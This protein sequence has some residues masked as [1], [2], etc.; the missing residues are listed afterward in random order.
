MSGDRFVRGAEVVAGPARPSATSAAAFRAAL[1]DTG[2][3]L[4]PIAATPRH[5]T[6][7]DDY[8]AQS[9]AKPSRARTASELERDPVKSM[10]HLQPLH[11]PELTV[12]PSPDS[13]PPPESWSWSA[14]CQ[15]IDTHF[16]AEHAPFLRLTLDEIRAK[17]V[18]RHRERT[19]WLNLVASGPSHSGK[20]LMA[21]VVAEVL[22]L[23]PDVVILLTDAETEGGLFGWSTRRA[24][25]GYRFEASPLLNLAWLCLDE[26]DKPTGEKQRAALKILQARTWVSRGGDKIRISP[27]ITVLMNRTPETVFKD[28][29]LRRSLCFNTGA[30]AQA[31]GLDRLQARLEDARRVILGV[32]AF[33][34]LNLD[35]L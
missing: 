18:L 13:A 11:P 20:S 24:G 21:E 23:D 35:D 22:G 29:F 4:T 30:V 12:L 15:T 2:R 31:I 8:E 16:P 25:A 14:F 28:E 27:A 6:G 33:E 34:R 7:H 3:W 5:E 32:A 17:H 1:S 26:F 19:G 10:N 9:R